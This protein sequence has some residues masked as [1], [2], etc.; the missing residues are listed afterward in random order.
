MRPS[1]MAKL[2]ELG[3]EWEF[4]DDIIGC[5]VSV[6]EHDQPIMCAAAWYRAEVHLALDHKWSTP[7]AR[8]FALKEL[9]D[10]MHEE[11]KRKHIGQAITWF[12]EELKRFKTRLQ[13]WGWVKS[14]LTSWHR[15]IDGI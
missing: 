4:N 12:G 8:L 5:L 6:D 3:V 15:R 13:A 7:G 11:L 1:D 10:A 9:H 14:Q 2:K